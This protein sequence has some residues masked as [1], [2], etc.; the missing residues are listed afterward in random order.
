MSVLATARGNPYV[1]PR[2]FERGEQLFGRDQEL[3]SLVDLVIA[4]RIVLLYSPSGAGKTS[5]LRASL[6]PQLE[7]EGFRVFPEIRVNA[8]PAAVD[9][10]PRPNRYLVST[11]LSLEK[12][13]PEDHQRDLDELARMTLVDYLSERRGERERGEDALED[14]DVL[15]F[16]QFEELLTIDITDQEDKAVFMDQLGAALRDRHRWAVIAMREDFVAGLD[17]FLRLLPT[18]LCTRFRLDLLGEAAARVAIQGP[19]CE[20]GVDF[21]DAAAQRLVDDLRT[22]RVPGR[23]SSTETLGPYIEPVQLQVVCER[24]WAR[25]R[26][27]ARQITVADIEGV[28]DVD[29]ALA[30]YYADKVRDVAAKT[31]VPEGLIR[32]WFDRK[33]ISERGLRGQV[34]DGPVAGTADE[35]SVL[36]S[37]VDAHLVRAEERRGTR[38]Y[39]LAHD[40]LIEPVQKNNAEWREAN[41]QPFQRQAALWHSEYR[42][43]RLLLIG[44]ALAEAGH[45]VDQHPNELTPVERQFLAASHA[46]DEREHAQR[47]GKRI[48]WALV[49]MLVVIGIGLI[50]FGGAYYA[51]QKALRRE[52]ASAAELQI[53]PAVALE[54]AL[55]ATKWPL[56]PEARAALTNSLAESHTRAILR[57]HSN[58]VS[59]ADFRPD[60]QRVVTVSNDGTARVWDA[61]TGREQRRL[62]GDK[63]GVVS[64][65]WS[66]DGAR[67]VTASHDGTAR[68]WDAATGREQQRLEGH[69]KSVL[70]AQWSGDGA[71]IVTASLDGTARVWDVVTGRQQWRLGH[72][73]GVRTAQWS[74]DGADIVTASLDGTARVWSPV[75]GALVATLPRRADPVPEAVFSADGNHVAAAG[76]DQSDLW[77]WETDQPPVPLAGNKPA[78]SSDGR[79]LLT[80]DKK[81]V[82]VWNAHRGETVVDLQAPT[83]VNVARFSPDGTRVVGGGEDGTIWIW[84]VATASRLVELHGHQGMVDDVRFSPTQP[85]FRHVVVSA[86]VDQTARVWDPYI[87]RVLSESTKPLK[88]AS[89]SADGTLVVGAGSDGVA[90]VWRSTTGEQLAELPAQPGSLESAEF[91]RDGRY[92]V[93]GGSDGI[94]RVWEWRTGRKRAE[95]IAV[96]GGVNAV[97]FDPSGKF[98]LIAGSGKDNV[99]RI[100]EWAAAADK[101]RL[102]RGHD[103]LITNAG[104]SPDGSLIVTA[105]LDKTAR[106]WDAVTGKELH[107]LRGHTG[108]VYGAKFSPDGRFVVTASDDKTARIWNPTTGRELRQLTDRKNSGL[109]DAAFSSDGNYIITGALDGVAGIWEA[110]TGRKL[111]LLPMHSDAVNSSQISPDGGLILTAGDDRIARLYDCQICAPIAELRKLASDRLRYIEGLAAGGRSIR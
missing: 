81:V 27:D 73:R 29:N 49:T 36:R 102:L 107:T 106:I 70:S 85:P 11:L 88:S 4:E 68:V 53:D 82:H 103:N 59:S 30:S 41:L 1:G 110:S 108:Q 61:T 43:E 39:E 14:Y 5:L 97:A 10:V 89:F 28:D 101:P 3:A 42:P 6:V 94:A 62:G 31:G 98:V 47:R 52:L 83:D 46:H 65:H 38:W 72:E 17:P 23:D 8:E 111:A 80:V 71:R 100:W 9:G 77:A 25:P 90:R 26:A 75:T 55:Q 40:R 54:K 34:I 13:V 20:A 33:L 66:P 45:W 105:S 79:H 12:G 22:V 69:E 104:F 2:A 19:A 50:A 58:S 24:L 91:S 92:I 21:S 86:G 51:V 63:D 56:T 64:A 16:D 60:G 93:T 96:G 84:D 95:N 44:D 74:P 87:G 67:I 18:R 109:K 76:V 99:A 32:D 48:Q 15:I 78:F 35:K 57:G 37:L 7:E